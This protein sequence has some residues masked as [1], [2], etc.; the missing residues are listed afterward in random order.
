M[1]GLAN[2][3]RLNGPGDTP[4]FSA[5]TMKKKITSTYDQSVAMAQ[6][7]KIAFMAI[8]EPRLIRV[9]SELM[10]VIIHRHLSGTPVVL[11]TLYQNDANGTPRL[12]AHR[13]VK[14][15]DDRLAGRG[16][17]NRVEVVAHAQRV[18]D[19]EDPAKKRGHGQ[20][21]RNGQR[22]GV[23]GVADLLGHS[24]RGVVA[25]HDPRH[26]QKAKQEC[27]AVVRPARAVD[28]LGE[29]VLL[30][31]NFWALDQHGDHERDDRADVHKTVVLGDSGEHGR[32]Q[33]VDEAVRDDHSDRRAGDVAGRRHVLV[34]GSHGNG[35]QQQRGSSEIGRA[36]SSHGP[37]E[38]QP[39][40]NPAD[41]RH[42]FFRHDVGDHIVHSTA[43]R[44]TRGDMGDRVSNGQ[45]AKHADEPRPRR[46]GRAAGPQRIQIGDGDGSHEPRDRQ[47]ERKRCQERVASV[48]LLLVAEMGQLGGVG[49]QS[50]SWRHCC[51]QIG[52]F[53]VFG[54]VWNLRAE[55]GQR[56]L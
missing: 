39:S 55:E 36:R 54:H 12:S 47:G 38:V 17:E 6:T 35:L 29:D 32:R 34:V 3:P 51:V 44:E 56:Y 50:H 42:V 40:V 30:G 15:L 31:I 43:G 45:A 16:V 26:V 27:P 48:E 22:R 41:K 11:S 20:G 14:H 52:F 46:S 10:R 7:E 53:Q 13:V 4:I 18:D 21:G 24:G 8:E 9:S 19:V 28:D 49:V 1:I 25:R 5:L 2:L 23:R 37:D 33:R